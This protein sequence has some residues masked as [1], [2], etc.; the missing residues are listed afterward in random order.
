ME[1]VASGECLK[2]NLVS[3]CQHAN[4][5][6]Y[7][8]G[9]PSKSAVARSVAS[10]SHFGGKLEINMSKLD[11]TWYVVADGGK[12][13]ILVHT[14]DGLRTQHSFDASGKSN[15]VE[16]ADSGVSQLKAPKSDPKDQSEAHFAKAVADY[17]NEAV[18][19]NQTDSL[20][21]AAS[22]QVLH[23]IREGLSK[24]AGSLV[25]KT[26][27]KDYVNLPDKELTSHFS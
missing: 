21:I 15:A 17:L 10:P 24:E 18:R 25:N 27:S 12:A 8:G 11:N 9:M 4:S 16:N 1:R 2:Y 13:R 3:E 7:C 5:Y 26:M 14:D 20:I 23:G 6:K 22:A 19:R